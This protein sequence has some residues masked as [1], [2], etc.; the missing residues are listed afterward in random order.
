LKSIGGARILEVF[1]LVQRNILVFGTTKN[2]NTHYKEEVQSFKN[3]LPI[4]LL[5]DSPFKKVWNLVI[6]M[7]LMYTATFVPYKVAF[8]D[9][10]P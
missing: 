3:K 9:D 6:M 4:I 2:I 1:R 10:N 7:L 8:M 5:P